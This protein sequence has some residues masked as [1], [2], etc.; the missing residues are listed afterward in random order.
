[1]GYH[2]ARMTV[3]YGVAAVLQEDNHYYRVGLGSFQSRAIHAALHP[4]RAHHRDG[5]YTI[6]IS[7][8]SGLAGA[9]FIS[10]M[11]LPPSEQG[12][13]EAVE[14]IL[15]SYAVSAAFD[16]A[17]EFVPDLLHKVKGK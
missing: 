16:E 2:A 14:N 6:S 3:Q 10:R 17:R 7:S 12:V 15:V 13:N 9:A 4:A 8:L 5:S 1:M 11:W